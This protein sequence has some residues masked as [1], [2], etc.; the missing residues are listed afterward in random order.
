MK[1]NGFTQLAPILLRIKGRRRREKQPNKQENKIS[2]VIFP[3]CNIYNCLSK[4]SQNFH[5]H[6]SMSEE[7][8]YRAPIM[9]EA[10]RLQPTRTCS[11]A[12]LQH[13]YTGAKSELAHV[14]HLPLTDLSFECRLL[15]LVHVLA[16]HNYI[17]NATI[18]FPACHIWPRSSKIFVL[19]IATKNYYREHPAEDNNWIKQVYLLHLYIY[20]C[21]H[22]K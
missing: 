8:Q 16:Y 4:L 7:Q 11:S 20:I 19:L 18:C 6:K 5:G 1:W 21:I 13:L 12:G 9:Q 22:F 10:S 14:Q 2:Q 3:L 15:L 17:T